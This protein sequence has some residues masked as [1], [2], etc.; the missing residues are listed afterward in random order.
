MTY[1]EN[2]IEDIAV[3]KSKK[4]RKKQ[5]HLTKLQKYLF[6]TKTWAELKLYPFAVVPDFSKFAHSTPHIT[7]Y[8]NSVLN[9]K[10]MIVGEPK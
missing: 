8:K 3:T 6:R 5:K 7:R 9:T 4:S 1:R 2:L 10:N